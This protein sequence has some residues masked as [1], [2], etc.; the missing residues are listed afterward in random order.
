LDD[1]IGYGVLDESDRALLKQ[2]IQPV[3]GWSKIILV[4][5]LNRCP[6]ART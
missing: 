2:L 1:R 6:R 3:H 5:P 4:N